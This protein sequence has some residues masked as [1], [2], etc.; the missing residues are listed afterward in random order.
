MTAIFGNFSRF[1]CQPTSAIFNS[2]PSL[3]AK[4]RLLDIMLH[5]L[6]CTNLWF[7]AWIL[8][9]VNFAEIVSHCYQPFTVR[10]TQSIDVCSIWTLQPHAYRKHDTKMPHV[11]HIFKVFNIQQKRTLRIFF[12]CVSLTHD[13]EAQNARIGS[14]LTILTLKAIS[15]QFTASSHVPCI[16]NKLCYICVV[17]DMLHA[18]NAGIFKCTCAL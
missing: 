9:Q 11:Q 4:K 17:R 16:K 18:Y 2:C 15:Q 10:A 8:E 5:C 12:L 7:K 3:A 14:P 1:Q 13:M 6:L